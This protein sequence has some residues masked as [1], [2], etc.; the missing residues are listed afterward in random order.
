MRASFGYAGLWFL[1]LLSGCEDESEH[2][3]SDGKGTLIEAIYNN[4]VT[5]INQLMS[6]GVGLDT[7]VDGHT[8]II[9][10][11]LVGD[12]T[13]ASQ[14]IEAGANPKKTDVWGE[15]PLFIAAEFNCPTVTKQLARYGANVDEVWKGDTA[16]SIAIKKNNA[17]VVFALLRYKPK[18]T[19][20][21]VQLSE[22]L[23]RDEITNVL[24]EYSKK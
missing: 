3:F 9:V 19:S 8:P 23:G 16:L 10:A 6:S 20:D 5:T 15:P 14:L 24:K 12:Q 22:S 13:L 1:L 2:S 7:V 17:E 4:D 18:I 11:M 21:I